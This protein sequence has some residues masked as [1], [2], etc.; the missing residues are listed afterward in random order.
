[1]ASQPIQQTLAEDPAFEDATDTLAA[2][3]VDSNARGRA[4]RSQT[5]AQSSRT[6]ATKST[7]LTPAPNPPS[8][9]PTANT[10]PKQCGGRGGSNHRSHTLGDCPP[11]GGPPSSPPFTGAR[12]RVR[13]F[14][15]SPDT[16]HHFKTPGTLAGQFFS[17]EKRKS[18]VKIDNPN[19]LPPYISN[20]MVVTPKP[21]T[22]TSSG[23][24]LATWVHLTFDCM[25]THAY[26]FPSEEVKFIWLKSLIA[27]EAAEV[28]RPY[29]TLSNL[30]RFTT[31]CD[32][33]ERLRQN[34]ATFFNFSNLFVQ[35]AAIAGVARSEWKNMMNRR[36]ELNLRRWVAQ[37]FLNLTMD[38]AAFWAKCLQVDNYYR[39]IAQGERTDRLRDAITAAKTRVPV[40]SHPLPARLPLAPRPTPLATT[41]SPLSGRPTT[42][43]PPQTS[44]QR[45]C[46][47]CGQ[48]GQISPECPHP[49]KT[50]LAYV[51]TENIDGKA[52]EDQENEPESPQDDA[53]LS[54]KE[55]P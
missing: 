18:V 9:Q 1:M 20:P 38:F 24:S 15:A 53:E 25:V 19:L 11:L 3:T 17:G 7:A 43:R 46:F 8:T 13:P 21:F 37:E 30:D 50:A 12:D 31:S 4:T 29:L 34:S 22:G 39:E 5:R 35:K 52:E 14:S 51:E 48:P 44:A 2:P 32:D 26:S 54:R 10:K 55:E 28:L 27:N 42:A 40:R 41:P 16:L 33:L 6:P 47:N 45:K 36:M 23:P 49:R